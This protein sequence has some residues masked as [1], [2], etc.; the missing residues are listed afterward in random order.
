[1]ADGG[2]VAPEI[3][4]ADV[5]EREPDAGMH[6]GVI[7]RVNACNGRMV[8][9]DLNTIRRVDVGEVG[10][11]DVGVGKDVMSD[12]FGIVRDDEA[13]IAL[14]DG[15]VC[16]EQNGVNHEIHQT[17]ERKTRQTSNAQRPTSNIQKTCRA[18]R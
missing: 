17:H 5:A 8:A 18:R 13:V 7:H 14:F 11:K 2:F 16:G 10:A 9:R 1:M 4:T 12:G 15:E 6:G 3:L